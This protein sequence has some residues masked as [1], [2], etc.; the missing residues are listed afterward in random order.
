LRD[1]W[2]E[3]KRKSMGSTQSFLRCDQGVPEKWGT[4]A[5]EG[6]RAR[7]MMETNAPVFGD[8]ST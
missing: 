2:L 8:L 5:Y 6:K 4:C 7:E 3:R 1:T